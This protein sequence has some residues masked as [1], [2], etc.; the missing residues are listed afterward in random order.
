MSEQDP[1]GKDAGMGEEPVLP[2]EVLEDQAL[3]AELMQEE[4]ADVVRPT[5]LTAKSGVFKGGRPAKR[6]DL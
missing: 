4:L 5:P 6:V 3:Q 2:A 1:F